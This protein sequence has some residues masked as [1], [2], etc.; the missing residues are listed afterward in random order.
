[1]EQT[2]RTFKFEKEKTGR[3]YIVLPGWTGKRADLEMVQGA[4]K[5]LDHVGEGANEVTLALNEQPFFEATPLT[6]YDG[7]LPVGG[8]MYLLNKYESVELNQQLWLCAVTEH[9][10]G[11]LPQVIYFKR[12]N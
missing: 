3:W 2:I 10:F 4:D 1:M 9:V 12:V 6:L 5:M 8:G 7:N 11:H